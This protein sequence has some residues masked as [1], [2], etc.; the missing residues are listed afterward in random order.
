MKLRN[1]F[2]LGATALLTVGVARAQPVEVYASG[3]LHQSLGNAQFDPVNGRRLPI[4]N[5]GSSGQDGVEIKF[6]SR[7]GGQAGGDYSAL[8]VAGSELHVVATDLTGVVKCSHTMV[9]QGNGMVTHTLDYSGMGAIELRTITYD[10]SGLV[11]SD[12]LTPGPIIVIDAQIACASPCYPVWTWINWNGVGMMGWACVCAEPFDPFDWWSQS[13]Q[14]TIIPV[15]PAGTTDTSGVASL[16]VTGANVPE[17]SVTH[18]ALETFDMAIWGLGQAQV[19]EV[20]PIPPCDPIDLNVQV[21]NIGSSGQDG[22]AIGLAADGVVTAEVETSEPPFGHTVQTWKHRKTT[23]HV[24]LMKREIVPMPGLNEAELLIDFSGMG[25]DQYDVTLYDAADV[26]LATQRLFNGVAYTISLCPAGMQWVNRWPPKYSGCELIVD[27]H[28]LTI[29][30]IGGVASMEFV[31]VNPT[32]QSAHP[33]LFEITGADLS[34]PLL[35]RGAQVTTAGPADANCDGTV[36]FF[37]IDPLLL[38]LFNPGGY[39]AQYAGCGNGDVNGDGV[40]DFFDIDPFLACLF[41]GCP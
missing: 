34:A 10:T 9:G 6:N 23:G 15:L 39:E 38:A 40:T 30:P 27:P 19:N 21:S 11:L 33:S 41:S 31:P 22:V 2:S 4:R 32:M 18:G 20:C 17:T 13:W 1:L 35:V 7:W 5:L 3:L 28:G 26:P 36:D 16:Y 29:G 12:V 8:T 24:T 37:D 14:R 25:A